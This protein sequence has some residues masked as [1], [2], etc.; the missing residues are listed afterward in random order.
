MR[1]QAALATLVFFLAVDAAAAADR[2][3]A[4]LP[5]SSSQLSLSASGPSIP[6]GAEVFSFTN[7]SSHPCTLTGYPTFSARQPNGRTALQRIVHGGLYAAR[8]RGVRPSQ[9][10]VTPR[11]TAEFAV[12]WIDSPAQP[13]QYCLDPPVVEVSSAPPGNTDVLT[14]RLSIDRALCG[15]IT[16]GF[17]A[18]VLI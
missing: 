3:A 5:C 8:G 16:V 12:T 13:S 1:L 2:G 10:V 17:V 18:V 4:P 6:T 9:V 11:H 7:T 14:T 15:P